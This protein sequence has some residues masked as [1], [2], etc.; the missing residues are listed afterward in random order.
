MHSAAAARRDDSRMR[1]I[2]MLGDSLTDGYGL[3]RAQAFPALVAQRIRAGGMRYQV[4]NAG[5]SGDTTAGGLRR[6]PNYLAHRIDVLVLA[7]GINDAFRGIPIEQMRAN[8]QAIIERTKGR[9]PDVEI[10]IAGM[11]IPLFANDEYMRGFGDMFAELA[12][13]NDAAL[14]P[15]LLAGVGGNPELNLRDRIHPNAKGQRVLA[16]NVWRALKPVLRAEIAPAEG[17]APARLGQE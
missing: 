12:E 10:V 16:E 8:L 3:D 15:Y 14:I 5:V 17:R 2:L 9:R 4:I 6:I 1:T 13:K 7:L 11:Q